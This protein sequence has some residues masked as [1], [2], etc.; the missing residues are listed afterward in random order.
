MAKKRGKI[1]E[2]TNSCVILE[3]GI[4]TSKNQNG[5]TPKLVHRYIFSSVK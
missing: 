1:I 3:F 5:K 2:L 4:I